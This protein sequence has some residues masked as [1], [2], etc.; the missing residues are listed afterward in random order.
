MLRI[1]HGKHLL[2]LCLAIWSLDILDCERGEH[3]TLRVAKGEFVA[4]QQLG[5]ELFRQVGGSGIGQRVSS[6]RRNL[7]QTRSKSPL[8]M[9]SARG[10]NRPLTS[11]LKSHSWRSVV[12]QDLR[13]RETSLS[14]RRSA[15]ALK[16]TSE[17]PCGGFR[18]SP[19]LPGLPTP[20]TG[21]MLNWGLIWL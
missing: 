4:G 9:K 10:D 14:A 6:V 7:E 15:D 8:L 3:D 5:G 11:S 17:P 2:G 1:G 12:T 20:I 13:V 16:S 18:P 21:V 19:T